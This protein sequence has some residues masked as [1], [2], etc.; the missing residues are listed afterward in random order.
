MRFERLSAIAVIGIAVAS[1]SEPI[2][3]E[4]RIARN[5]QSADEG[6]RLFQV[7]RHKLLVAK[8]WEGVG[9]TR[10]V[11]ITKWL[12]CRHKLANHAPLDDCLDHL[13]YDPRRGQLDFRAAIKQCVAQAKAKQARL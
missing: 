13:S 12:A 11:V 4:Q 8:D 1:C 5:C 7:Y 6:E 3:R 10:Q 9:W 2:S